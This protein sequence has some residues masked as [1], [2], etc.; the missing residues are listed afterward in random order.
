MPEENKLPEGYGAAAPYAKGKAPNKGAAIIVV[1][2]GEKFISFL[3]RCRKSGKDMKECS[4]IW[5]KGPSA[6]KSDTNRRRAAR[7]LRKKKKAG[8]ESAA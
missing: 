3:A 4:V 7:I 8:G 6:E 1:Q 2:K 5:K